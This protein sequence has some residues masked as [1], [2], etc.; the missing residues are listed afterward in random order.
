MKYNY[1]KNNVRSKLE[2]FEH[3][4]L[5]IKN[6]LGS[7]SAENGIILP[8]KDTG[9]NMATGGVFHSDMQFIET[10]ANEDAHLYEGAERE[11]CISYRD[12]IVIYIGNFIPVWGHAIT[13]NL[14]KLWFIKTVEGETLLESGAHLVY[15]MQFGKRMPQY[16]KELLAMADIDP[17]KIVIEE[18]T[19][20]TRFKKV[21][22]PDNS[23]EIHNGLRYY[24]QSYVEI[25]NIIANFVDTHYSRKML[26][27][28]L[29]FTRTK[30]SSNRDKG[31]EEIEQVFVNLGYKVIAPEQ[32]SLVDQIGMLRHCSFFAT[33]EG[34]ISHS[35]IFCKPHTKVIILRKA[36]WV[37]T[38]QI[39][40]N[41][42]A[43]LDVTYIDVHHSLRNNAVQPW[44]G[45]F[46]LCV[47]KY[48]ENYVG[49]KIPHKSLWIRKDWLWYYFGKYKVAHSIN[50]LIHRL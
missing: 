21:I 35:A 41:K 7:I 23:I 22:V 39:M 25:V 29:Y 48:L 16:M 10:S 46:Y 13:D 19:E 40:I 8:W 18:I 43:A 38:Y 31:E 5:E 36:D 42:A 17:N 49:H 1:V 15:I 44:A 27:E 11:T 34:S 32:Y 24:H 30:L 20:P 3:G 4:D 50:S 47:T 26:I 12:E 28:K 9:D 6:S 14:K 2:L 45:P 37:N 33:T